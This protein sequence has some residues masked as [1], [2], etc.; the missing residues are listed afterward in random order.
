M[1]RGEG[2]ASFLEGERRALVKGGM[3]DLE[4]LDGEFQRG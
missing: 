3:K 2:E 1:G 4:S